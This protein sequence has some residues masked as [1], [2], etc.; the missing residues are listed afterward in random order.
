MWLCVTA[1][2]GVLGGGVLSMM[3]VLASGRK[4]VTYVIVGVSAKNRWSLSY[5]A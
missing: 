3:R 1:I 2:I 5:I 4:C